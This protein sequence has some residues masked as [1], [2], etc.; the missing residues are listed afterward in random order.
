[1]AG[2]EPASFATTVIAKKA[3]HDAG[4]RRAAKTGYR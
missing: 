2:L 1:M 4:G 3:G